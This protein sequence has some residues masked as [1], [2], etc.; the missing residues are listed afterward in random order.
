MELPKFIINSINKNETSIGDNPAIPPGDENKFIL[1][2]VRNVF[3]ELTD[4]VDKDEIEIKNELYSM[5]QK[6]KKEENGIR[7]ELEKICLSSVLKIIPIPSDTVTIISKINDNI[8]SKNQRIIPDS[9]DDYTFE[10]IDDMENLTKEIYKRR[11]LDALIYGISINYSLK[12]DLYVNEIFNLN[13][14]LPSLYAKIMKYNTILTYTTKDSINNENYEDAGRVDVFMY[15][16]DESVKII[17]NGIIFPV[18]LY[19]TIK[20][21]L[22]LCISHGLPE[23]ISKAEYVIKK[24]DFKLADNWDYRIGYALWKNIENIM[25]KNNIDID[26]YGVHYFT[27]QLSMI[28]CEK[29]NYIMREILAGTKLGIKTLKD[30]LYDIKNKIDRDDFE[31][32]MNDKN[33]EYDSSNQEAFFTPDELIIKND[34]LL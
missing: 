9:T 25:K 10:S 12:Y 19:E 4:G 29:F 13:P 26:E 5:I 31:T 34:T 1:K 18:L 28:P 24:S 14:D 32:Y 16:S 17:A 7:E 6:C 33:K 21:I 22:E 8:S 2:I 30:M 15:S 11:F 23:E 27:M 3:N 20:G